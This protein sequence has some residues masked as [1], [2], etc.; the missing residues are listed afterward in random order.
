MIIGLQTTNLCQLSCKPCPNSIMRAPKIEN[1]MKE[2]KVFK[3]TI[4]RMINF[5]LTRFQLTP[6]LG[7]PFT[8]STMIEKLEWMEGLPEVEMIEFFTN[9]LGL[10]ISDIERLVKLK[11]IRMCISVYGCTAESYNEFTGTQGVFFIWERNLSILKLNW[12]NYFP[13]LYFCIRNKDFY[14]KKSKVQQ[15]LIL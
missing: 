8:D 9:F 10:N 2:M 12:R 6:T 1:K 7:D 13:V 15:L 14:D 3:E 11:K 4:H 5:G